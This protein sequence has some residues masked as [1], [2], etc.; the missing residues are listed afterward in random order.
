MDPARVRE[1]AAKGGAAAHAAGKAHVFTSEEAQ[2]A[3]RKGGLI[4]QARA[5][6]ERTSSSSEPV[7]PHIAGAE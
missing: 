1:I 6:A 5:R 3:G 2:A 7:E 4:K